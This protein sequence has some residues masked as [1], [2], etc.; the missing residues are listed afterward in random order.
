M[1]QQPLQ[2]TAVSSD[3]HSVRSVPQSSYI[4]VY[5]SDNDVQ[6]LMRNNQV[7]I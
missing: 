5:E 6:N 3:N 4:G 7:N 1:Q 2:S